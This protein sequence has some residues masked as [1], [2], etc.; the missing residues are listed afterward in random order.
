M[1]LK[2]YRQTILAGI[3]PTMEIFSQ[4]LGCLQLPHDA[5][6]RNSL[7]ENLGVSI[8]SPKRS[9][10]YSLVDGFGEYD[11]RAFSLFEVRGLSILIDCVFWT[12]FFEEIS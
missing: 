6:L 10:L 12:L 5:S 8:D 11:P 3:V 9:T 1:A 7:V 4:V 2:V